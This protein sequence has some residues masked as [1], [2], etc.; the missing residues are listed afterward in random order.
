MTVQSTSKSSSKST[1]EKKTKA[2]SVKK[3][4][5]QLKKVL[6]K[7][8][9]S[10]DVKT[11]GQAL[12]KIF[13]RNQASSN[14]KGSKT[15]KAE[16]LDTKTG[17]ETDTPAKAVRSSKSK[18]TR[19]TE[20]GEI[21]EADV[22][23]DDG[24]TMTHSQARVVAELAGIVLRQGNRVF[25]LKLNS[26]TM[27][28]DLTR[29][30]NEQRDFMMGFKIPV[31]KKNGEVTKYKT[32]EFHT[33]LIDLSLKGKESATCHGYIDHAGAVAMSEL[34]LNWKGGVE[35]MLDGVQQSMF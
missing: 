19:I 15:G 26:A 34:I 24:E 30:W 14:S 6:K 20:D 5:K 29:I 33:K 1:S 28:K 35:F 7:T 12:D 23:D 18:Q 10:D 9:S 3:S 13:G 22:E 17:K 8:D 4:E 27:I 2:A 31:E 21:E 11:E 25:A 16:S 32:V